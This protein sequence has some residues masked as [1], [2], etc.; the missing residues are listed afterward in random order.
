MS[1]RRETASVAATVVVFG[2]FWGPLRS[3]LRGK[4]GF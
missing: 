2:A 1:K 4:G 3:L